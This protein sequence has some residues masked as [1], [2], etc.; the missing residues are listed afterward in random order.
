M[1]FVEGGASSEAVAHLMDPNTFD[2]FTAPVSV[3]GPAGKWLMPD[4]IVEVKF[5]DDEPVTGELAQ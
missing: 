1:L 2:Q 5:L 4:G 3:F